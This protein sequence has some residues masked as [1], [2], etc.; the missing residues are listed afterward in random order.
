MVVMPLDYESAV[1][2]QP[3]VA[4]RFCLVAFGGG[5]LGFLAWCAL[6]FILV[7]FAPSHMHDFDWL[8]LLFPFLVGGVGALLL[9]QRDSSPRVGLAIVAAIVASIVAVVLILFVGISFHLGIGG[10]L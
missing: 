3:P 10:N 7:R 4:G 2:A 5:G 1:P 6:D 9:R 8:M